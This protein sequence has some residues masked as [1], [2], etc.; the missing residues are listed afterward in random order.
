M[1]DRQARPDWAGRRPGKPYENRVV[2]HPPCPL[3]GRHRGASLAG[4]R[5]PAPT[6]KG[7]TFSRIPHAGALYRPVFCTFAA[8][9]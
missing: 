3:P 4:A 6:K 8:F 1:K 2:F 5:I 7:R 9:V